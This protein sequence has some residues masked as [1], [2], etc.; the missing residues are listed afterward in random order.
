VSFS[1]DDLVWSPAVGLEGQILQ[2]EGGRA[3]VWWSDDQASWEPLDV[4]LPPIRKG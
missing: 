1:V 3:Q 2:I 4:L